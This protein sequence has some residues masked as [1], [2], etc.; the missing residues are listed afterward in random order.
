MQRVQVINKKP[1]T[2]RDRLLKDR[3]SYILKLN[4]IVPSNSYLISAA[5][6]SEISYNIEEYIMNEISKIKSRNID[7]NDNYIQNVIR[8][9]RQLQKS[10]SR[11][12]FPKVDETYFIPGSSIKGAVRSRIEYK[13]MPKEGKSMSCYIVEDDFNPRY[14]INHIKFWG[15]RV[16]ISRWR[17]NPMRDNNICIVCDMFGSQLISSL[18]NFG[19]AYMIEGDVERL[20]EFNGLEAVKPNSRFELE[21][22]CF[23]FDH[24]RLG[25]LFLGFELFSKSPI[26]L[27]MF[28]YK[29][30]PN[31]TDK[32]FR[33]KYA[34]GLLRFELKEIIDDLEEHHSLDK[35]IQETNNALKNSEFNE[36]INWDVGVIKDY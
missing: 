29:Y 19:D 16:A 20:N 26:I 15:E 8:N 22:T 4:A 28:K 14:A 7:I 2:S 36:Y 13:F 12:I 21:V 24:I 33:G 18:V 25:L 35:I 27:G 17:C 31:I 9:I 23:N 1:Y 34:I 6:P 32:L 10:Q 3:R 11:N 5:I 30:N